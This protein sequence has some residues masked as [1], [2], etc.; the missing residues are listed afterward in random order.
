LTHLSLFAGIGGIDLGLSRAG[1][2]CVGM[3][4]IDP[5][6]RAVLAKNFPGVPLFQD[7]RSFDA[8]AFAGSVDLV[9]GG[10]PCQDISVAGKGAGIDGARS[11]LWSEMLRVVREVRP[12]WVLAENVPALR[13]RGADRV[14]GDLEGEGYACWPLL[15]GAGDVGA[16][17]R[18]QRVWIVAHAGLPDPASPSTNGRPRGSLNSRW[19]AQLM[20]YPPDW[21]ELPTDTLSA[22]TVTRSSPKSSSSS[23]A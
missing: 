16:P 13:T 20:G 23:A 10:F 22:L 17:H 14:L 15:V 18:R 21:C 2:R 11:G 6:C 7:V 8:R 3:V 5:F 4:E 1:S 19:V 9:A 12:A